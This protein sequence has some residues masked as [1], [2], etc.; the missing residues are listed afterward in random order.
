LSDLPGFDLPT[1]VATL[2]A[3]AAG[4]GARDV[5]V[6]IDQGDDLSPA[7]VSLDALDRSVSV[8]EGELGRSVALEDVRE[9]EPI[10]A[11]HLHNFPPFELDL[12]LGQVTGALG[13]LEDLARSLIG[14]A[15][16]FGGRSI[17]TASFTTVSGPPLEIGASTSGECSL[18]GGEV[19]FE[20]P[21][22]W[23]PRR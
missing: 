21:P 11:Q 15:A 12:E 17:A 7:V 2:R 4:T 16:M 6:V 19:E 5:S 13:A 14:L 23:P 18:S 9:S 20:T 3:F 22:D 1:T 8:V 10:A